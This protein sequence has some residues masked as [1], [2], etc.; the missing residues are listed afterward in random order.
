MASNINSA[1]IDETYPIAGVDN[2]TQ[3]FRDNFNYTKIGLATAATEITDLQ[4]NTAKINV[5]NDFNKKAITNAVLRN[6]IHSFLNLGTRSGAIVI[7][8][9]NADHQYVSLSGDAQF[10]FEGFPVDNSVSV[11]LEIR[12]DG[13]ARTITFPTD[14]VIPVLKA[15]FPANP[16]TVTSATSAM[17]VRV[18]TRAKSIDPG[19]LARCYLV[20]CMGVFN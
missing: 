1:Q 16:I 14:G 9:G 17:L 5:D 20:E 10:T 7:N 6:N 18:T 2:D 13:T 3:G 12:G 8:F 11:I 19:S 4:A 15:N